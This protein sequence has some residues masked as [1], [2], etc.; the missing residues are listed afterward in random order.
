MNNDEKICVVIPAYCEAGRIG[1]V[2]HGVRT[3]DLDVVVVDDGSPDATAAEAEA[4]GA[5][6]LRHALN[7]GKGAALQ[8]AYEFVR[9]HGYAAVIT[10][11]GDGQ[12]DPADIPALLAAA[13]TTG[14][15]VVVGNRLADTAAMPSVRRRTNRLMSWLLG[16]VMR[17]RVPDTQCGFRYY[18]LDVLPAQPPASARFAAE[19][20]LLLDLA[21]RGVRIASAP[22]RTIYRDEQSKINPVVDTLRFLGMMLRRATRRERG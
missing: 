11:D 8:T 21:A 9:G 10:M 18:R 7:R 12:H 20:E 13:R 1:A 2:V 6:V 3:Q 15:P 17:Q 16:C 4:A 5:T 22:V 19:S 14:A